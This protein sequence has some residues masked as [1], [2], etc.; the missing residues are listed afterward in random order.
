MNEWMNDSG[1]N[2]RGT[3]WVPPKSNSFEF[4][5]PSVSGWKLPQNKK[6]NAFSKSI[7][8]TFGFFLVG[9]PE[10]FSRF[11]HKMARVDSVRVRGTARQC[12]FRRWYAELS[13]GCS[14]RGV[15][16]MGK[17]TQVRRGKIYPWSKDSYFKE[18]SWPIFFFE[19]LHF[20]IRGWQDRLTLN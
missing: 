6:W 10:V 7:F 13:Q 2:C 14:S 5:S 1:P 11:F 18:W 19:I 9:G 3:I 15:W 16:G 20:E 8:Q 17:S 12:A 4:I